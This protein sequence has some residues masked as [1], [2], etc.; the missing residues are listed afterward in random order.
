MRNPAACMQKG[1]LDG[2]MFDHIRF[3]A[4]VKNK[5]VFFQRYT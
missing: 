5:C 3:P 4:T 2:D 1:P